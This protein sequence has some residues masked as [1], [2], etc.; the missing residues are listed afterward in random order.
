M[1]GFIEE[2]GA[3]QDL[4]AVLAALQGDTETIGALQSLSPALVS[5]LGNAARNNAQRRMNGSAGGGIMQRR[6]LANTSEGRP[7]NTHLPMT[8][9]NGAVGAAASVD[10]TATPLRAFKPNQM[11]VQT[12]GPAVTVDQV[13]VANIPMFGSNA[14]QVAA[15]AYRAD[16]VQPYDLDW[17]VIPSNQSLIA[18]CTNRHAATAC[19]IFGA[20]FGK[21]T[22]G[23]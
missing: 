6:I 1:R 11:I 12:D 2:I 21:Y 23:D 8:N 13:T 19:A 7:L 3:E 9:G 14:G 17:S 22:L 15:D 16:C 5:A 20:V 18:T 4:D 10:L